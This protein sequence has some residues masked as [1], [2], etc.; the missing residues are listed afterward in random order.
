VVDK[1]WHVGSPTRHSAVLP[2]PDTRGCSATV[3]GTLTAIS[4][5]S[6]PQRIV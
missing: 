1:C 3:N 4:R 2:D 6:A 5:P